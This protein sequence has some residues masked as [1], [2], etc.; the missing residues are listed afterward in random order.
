MKHICTTS[1]ALILVAMLAMSLGGCKQE[2]G[3]SSLRL[4]MQGGQE[5]NR[6]ILPED[7]PLEVSRYVVTGEGPQNSTFEVQTT[8]PSVE[9][10]GLLMGVWNVTALG[11]NKQGLNLVSGSTTCTISSEPTNAL[12]ELN[13]LTGEGTMKINFTWDQDKITHPSIDLWVIDA[14]GVSTKVNPTT[15]NYMNGSVS[16]S[17]SY[18]AGSYLIKSLLHS[19]NTVVA[20]SVEV[21]RI[22]GNKVTE[23]TIPLALDKYPEIPSTVTLVNKAGTPIVCSISG[24]TSTVSA[25]EEVHAK[26]T[27]P[28]EQS[29]DE[30]SVVWYLNGQEISSSTTCTFTPNTGTHRLDLIAQGAL[31]ASSGSAS[32][33]FKAIVTG[34]PGKPMLV[35]SVA[36]NTNGLK[37]GGKTRVAF[38]PDGKFLLASTHHETLQIC[39]IVRDSFEV[40]RTYTQADGFNTTD[41]TDM[42]VER[43]SGRVAIADNR[44]PGITLYQYNKDTCSLT[45]LFYRNNVTYQYSGTDVTFDGIDKLMLDPITGT[46]Y[47]TVPGI[48]ML[49]MT[50][51]F[52]TEASEFNMYTYYDWINNFDAIDGIVM[53]P[54]MDK[55]AWFNTEKSHLRTSIRTFMNVPFNSVR[56]YMHP[57]VPY[58]EGISSAQF[59]S[60]THLVVGGSKTLAVFQFSPT[61]TSSPNEWEQKEAWL[62]N[63]NNIGDMRGVVHLMTNSSMSLLYALCKESRNI[64][65]FS[66]HPTTG[67]LTYLSTVSLGNFIPYKA[68][69]SPDKEDMIIISEISNELLLFKIP[70]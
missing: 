33:T 67:S 19:G 14:D 12:I 29:S 69:I 21:V 28:P 24:I 30:L 10:E 49:P 4:T 54:F 51:F 6:S 44:H 16:Y 23:G 5:Q 13:K 8:N 41:I 45:K 25:L 61:P 2:P 36:D 7:T 66:I 43:S 57:E 64:K 53:S 56:D 55:V 65:V 1:G 63:Q 9:V 52:A 20:G 40:V 32:I 38:L 37:I 68:E 31:L 34:T 42:L 22:V 11:Q 3:R 60:D 58:L 17:G 18:P 47:N 35:H 26:I 27:V 50:N 48:N 70:Q 62:S 39:R 46:L 59:I 15:N